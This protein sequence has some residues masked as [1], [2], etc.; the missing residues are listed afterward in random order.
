MYVR[1]GARVTGLIWR[2]R[3]AL[4]GLM[5]IAAGTEL[6]DALTP[7]H[8][9]FSLQYV[10]ILA[11][12]LSIFLV[13][14]FNEA[15]ERW[16]EARR[17]WGEVVNLS[18]DFARQ[19]LTLFP[20]DADHGQRRR[21]VRRQ[22]AF[23][24]ALRILLR[25]GNT[26]QGRAELEAVLGRLVPDEADRLLE[27]GNVPLALLQA[28]SAQLGEHMRA[29]P[30]D[31]VLL[32][33]FDSTLGRLL[34]AQGGCERIKNTPFPQAVA[35]VTRLLVWGM[36]VMLFI[37]TLEP[38]GRGGVGATVA[39]ALMA[40]GF[41]WIDTLGRDLNDPFESAPNDTPMTALAITIERDLGEM[42]GETDLPE[43]ATPHR[44]VL[45]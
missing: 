28:H 35:L 43:V 20:G 33:R 10:G 45:L 29:T 14:R 5:L 36:A 17:L 26:A 3:R 41:I 22:A 21:L 12:A 1:N 16:W 18:R 4:L 39:V 19:A 11:T 37:V 30:T 24:H 2:D 31:S 32:T 34:D 9:L 42:L 40:M 7:A 23:P 25:E 44:G 13:F 38:E 6:F 27:R 15:Y 8:D